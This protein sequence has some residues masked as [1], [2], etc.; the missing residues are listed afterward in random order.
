MHQVIHS[1]EGV[2]VLTVGLGQQCIIQISE[3]VIVST[4]WPLAI[5]H[6]AIQSTSEM[7]VLTVKQKGMK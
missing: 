7:I 2:V 5:V 1:T 3:G 6:Q 4:V